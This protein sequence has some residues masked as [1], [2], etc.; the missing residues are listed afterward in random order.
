MS[1]V[2][3]AL[4]ESELAVSEAVV[5]PY[6]ADDVLYPVEASPEDNVV[7]S[8]PDHSIAE[9]VTGTEALVTLVVFT[10]LGLVGTRGVEFDISVDA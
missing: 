5:C 7:E 1:E 6:R 3:D 8:D 9:D 2:T 4:A 10:A